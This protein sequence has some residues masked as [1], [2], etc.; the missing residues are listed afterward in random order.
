MAPPVERVERKVAIWFQLKDGSY[1][2]DEL[3]YDIAFSTLDVPEATY[4]AIADSLPPG[5]E[6]SVG[7]REIVVTKAQVLCR[8][9]T[10][11]GWL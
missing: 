8:L 2:T 3:H 7:G 11:T 4:Q 5:S 9:V 10:E 6:I 1:P